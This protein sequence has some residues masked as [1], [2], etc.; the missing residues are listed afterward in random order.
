MK[1]QLLFFAAFL[2]MSTSYSQELSQEINQ[3]F[4]KRNIEPLADNMDSEIELTIEGKRERMK[5]PQAISQIDNFLQ[6]LSSSRFSVIHKSDKRD[7]GFI[8]GTLQSEKI[9][10]RV[11]ISFKKIDNKEIIQTIRIEQINE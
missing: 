1:K 7:A 2:I 6:S 11:N 9:A 10:Y 5:G 8:I 3:S 4:S